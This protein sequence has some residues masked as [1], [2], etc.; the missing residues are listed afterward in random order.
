MLFPR[1]VYG[2]SFILLCIRI[3]HFYDKETCSLFFVYFFFLLVMKG[4]TPSFVRIILVTQHYMI[5]NHHFNKHS[6]NDLYIAHGTNSP[7]AK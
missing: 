7:R 6:L 2:F 3:L 1:L 5:Q 4:I